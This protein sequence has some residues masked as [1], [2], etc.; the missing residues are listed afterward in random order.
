MIFINPFALTITMAVVK[1][2]TTAT[3]T[4]LQSISTPVPRPIWDIALGAKPKPIIII[5][6]PIT[7]GG[8]ILSNQFFPANLIIIAKIT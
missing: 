6:G 4:P 8:K 2:V 5:I 1:N 3:I 7:T